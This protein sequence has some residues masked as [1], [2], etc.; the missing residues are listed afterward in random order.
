MVNSPSRPNLRPLS[1]VE[2]GVIP[3]RPRSGWGRLV[4]TIEPAGCVPRNSAVT[5]AQSRQKPQQS[6]L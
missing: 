6:C 5:Q 2:S 3:S 4:P 1:P